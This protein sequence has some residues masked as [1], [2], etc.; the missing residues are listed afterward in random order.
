MIAV[1][2]RRWTFDHPSARD[3]RSCPRRHGVCSQAAPVSRRLDLQWDAAARKQRSTGRHSVS[4]GAIRQFV[5]HELPLPDPG[6]ALSN[7]TRSQSRRSVAWP[8]RSSISGR[9]RH[10]SGRLLVY[11]FVE[12]IIEVSGDGH[13][14]RLLRTWGYWKLRRPC[15]ESGLRHLRRD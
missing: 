11:G 9:C 3:Q 15:G 1:D 7:A 6:V 10:S 14:R 8:L 4:G 13:V 2:T 5:P 12:R